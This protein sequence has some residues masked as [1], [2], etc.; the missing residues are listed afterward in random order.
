MSDLKRRTNGEIDFT[1]FVAIFWSHKFTIAIIS[2]L[3]IVFSV[4]YFSSITKLYTATSVFRSAKEGIDLNISS[5]LRPFASLAGIG[6]TGLSNVDNLIERIQSREFILQV[7]RELSL[8]SDPLFYSYSPKKTTDPLWRSTIK[9]LLN[10]Q[11][12]ELDEA[13][14]KSASIVNSY[15]EYV[16]FDTTPAGAISLSVTHTDPVIAAKYANS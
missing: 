4:Y 7:N 16:K 6:G 2:A 5:E 9:R 8:E 11:S 13:T 3:S 12:I 14:I 10:W 15:K 1:I